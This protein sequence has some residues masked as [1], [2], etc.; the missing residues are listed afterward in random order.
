MN[1]S[2]KI[3]LLGVFVLFAAV[4]GFV[5][6]SGGDDKPDDLTLNDEAE[7]QDTQQQKPEPT[8]A[9]EEPEP[10]LEPE[11]RSP[12]P[13]LETPVI[14]EPTVVEEETIGETPEELP[15]APILGRFP[16][17]TLAEADPLSETIRPAPELVEAPITEDPWTTTET[18][19]EPRPAPTP[20]TVDPIEE[21]TDPDPEPVVEPS[22]RP[23]PPDPASIPRTYTVQA[24][25]TFASIAEEFYGEERA[26]FNIAQANPSVDP[27]RLQV[28]QEIVL[29]NLDTVVRER[30]E[31][32]PPAP[33]RDQ[34]YTVRPGDNLSKIAQRF[35]G[36]A[37]KW[38]LIYARNRQLIGPRPDALKVGME[39]VIPQAYDGAE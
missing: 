33:G 30:E 26:W 4:I 17:G 5:I 28:G 16:E 37:E 23:I 25:D 34:S 19:V 36:E 39:L 13:T 6:F 9:I 32:Q 3:V 11:P 12:R 1:A 10:T 14:E 29:P 35:Y 7:E 2:Y 21:T 22:P 27:K 8:P 18:E 20:E 31:V 38:D 15:E 24:G